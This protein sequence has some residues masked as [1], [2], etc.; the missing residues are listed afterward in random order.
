MQQKYL[1][2]AVFLPY[3]VLFQSFFFSLSLVLFLFLFFSLLFSKSPALPCRDIWNL[4]VDQRRLA[5][6]K[7]AGNQ[8]K[9]QLESRPKHLQSI[10]NKCSQDRMNCN[11]LFLPTIKTVL[12]FLCFLFFKQCDPGHGTNALFE[13]LYTRPQMIMLLGAAC[14]SVTRATAQIGKL[15]NLLQV[16][17][18]S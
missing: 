16:S 4:E 3:I 11:L 6:L 17:N 14:S 2:I 7:Q 5:C 12:Y 8:E 15:W 13:S 18:V 10:A 1:K 9:P